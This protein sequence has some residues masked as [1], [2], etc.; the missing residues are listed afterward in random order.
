MYESPINVTIENMIT[1]VRKKQ[2]EAVYRAI[3]NVGINVN[4][5]ELIKA[6]QYDR[7]Q[8]NKGYKDGVREFAKRFEEEFFVCDVTYAI[9]KRDF[10]DFV[11]EMGV[12][13]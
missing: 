7:E 13:I 6:L 1:D 4:K 3:Q 8:Y 5:D 2:D 9:T 10:H 11:K 12:D